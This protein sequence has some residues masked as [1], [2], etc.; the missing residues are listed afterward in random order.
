MRRSGVQFPFWARHHHRRVGTTSRNV[1]QV[2]SKCVGHCLQRER[3]VATASPRQLRTDRS[4]T[5]RR[6]IGSAKALEPNVPG[7]KWRRATRHRC[8]GFDQQ[9]LIL[10]DHTQ[11]ITRSMA[12]PRPHE[13]QQADNAAARR[14]LRDTRAGA[15]S[16]TSLGTP[17]SRRSSRLGQTLKCGWI[18]VN[19]AASASPPKIRRKEI[20]PPSLEVTRKLLT[21]ADEFDVEFA[22][23][24]RVLTATG[25]RRGQVCGIRWSDIDVGARTLST[26]RRRSRRHHE[27]HIDTFENAPTTEGD[28]KRA[29]ELQRHLAHRGHHAAPLPRRRARGRGGRDAQTHHLAH[30]D[31]D[32][33]LVSNFTCQPNQWVVEPG[34]A[35]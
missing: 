31:A 30:Y 21:T 1:I 5:A 15:W 6:G 4:A 27:P 20:S 35:D 3:V 19:P 32:F 12:R 22:A 23:L 18:P 14:L 13:A 2:L 16:I 24:L 25:A 8:R 28:H 11:R 10:V 34:S 17:R 26:Q 9:A 33:E 7:H 29:L